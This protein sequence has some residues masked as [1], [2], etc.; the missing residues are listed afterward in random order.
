MT[1]EQVVAILREFITDLNNPL[2]IQ[3]ITKRLNE[4][5]FTLHNPHVSYEGEGISFRADSEVRF[6][7]KPEGVTALFKSVNNTKGIHEG[8][9]LLNILN[10][11]VYN[12]LPL[13][14]QV[15]KRKFSASLLRTSSDLRVKNL[16]MLNL[17]NTAP[18]ITAKLNKANNIVV[19]L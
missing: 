11:L 15:E 6:T 1:Q 4:I 5:E 16:Y 18:E 9:S 14:S 2:A 13:A 19:I 7:I 12:W 17:L 10:G 3:S 8:L